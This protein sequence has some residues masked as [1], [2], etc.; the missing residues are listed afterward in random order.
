MYGNCH[1]DSST[2]PDH[3]GH[4]MEAYRCASVRSEAVTVSELAAPVFP[5]GLEGCRGAGQ[6]TQG[7]GGGEP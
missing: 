1:Q 5:G 6:G 3:A 7:I 2:E 4:V